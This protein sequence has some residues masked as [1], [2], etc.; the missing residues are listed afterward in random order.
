MKFWVA[1]IH[2]IVKDTI[3]HF[4]DLRVK[5]GDLNDALKQVSIILLLLQTKTMQISS[6]NILK[7]SGKNSSISI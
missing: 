4:S 1:E 3:L 7:S 2:E 6:E 5:C